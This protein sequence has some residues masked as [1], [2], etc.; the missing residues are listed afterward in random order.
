MY[1]FLL[2]YEIAMGFLSG[3]TACLGKIWLLTYGPKSYQ[4]NENAGFF[5]LQ[6]LT[7][8]LRYE[9]EFLNS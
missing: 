2:D 9:V 6:Y 7:N 5:K 1:F 4:T 3:Q 8:E